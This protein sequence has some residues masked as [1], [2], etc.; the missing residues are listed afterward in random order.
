[1]Q[2]E[3]TLDKYYTIE[4]NTFQIPV[5]VICAKKKRKKTLTKHVQDAEGNLNL[6]CTQ[7]HTSEV[8]LTFLGNTKKGKI[9]T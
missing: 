6:T 5:F 8:S 3:K 2:C 7:A 9:T 4:M 1:M